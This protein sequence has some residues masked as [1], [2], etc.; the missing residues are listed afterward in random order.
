[1]NRVKNVYQY[2]FLLVTNEMISELLKH[3]YAI[4]GRIPISFQDDVEYK[5][6]QYV[7]LQKL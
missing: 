7:S 1:M 2:M 5:I 4:L 6:R 3:I